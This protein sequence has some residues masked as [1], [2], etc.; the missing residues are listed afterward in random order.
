MTAA[1]PAAEARA[2]PPST[3]RPVAVP[4]PAVRPLPVTPGRDATPTPVRVPAG[5]STRVREQPTAPS[6]PPAAEPA[7][8]V[9]PTVDGP[10]VVR[11]A[12]G[13]V[14]DPAV[15][16]RL[17]ADPLVKQVVDILDAPVQR[18]VPRRGRTPAAPPSGDGE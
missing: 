1:V 9:R 4:A 17:R 7:A 12:A 16:D 18:V 6:M 2:L 15:A 13:R 14:V 3:P 11:N 10:A 5:E 8:D